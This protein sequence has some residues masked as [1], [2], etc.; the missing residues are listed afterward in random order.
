M[1]NFRE[2]EFWKRSR[3]L[4][5]EVYRVTNTFP[6]NELYGLTS[7]IRRCAISI[8]SNIAEGSGRSSKKDFARFLDMSIGSAHELETQI[9]IAHEISFINTSDFRRLNKEL[10]EIIKMIS[11]YNNQIRQ[12]I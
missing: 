9:D 2:I 5:I 4:A 7:Q 3:H 6:K 8:P 10:I 11:R 12:S 1:I